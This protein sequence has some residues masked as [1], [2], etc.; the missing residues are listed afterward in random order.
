V[1]FGGEAAEKHLKLSV[2]FAPLCGA[3]TTKKPVKTENEYD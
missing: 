3:K 2:V 1:F